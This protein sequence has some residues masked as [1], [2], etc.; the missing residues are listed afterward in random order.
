MA[1]SR[2]SVPR[3]GR[4]A[5][6]GSVIVLTLWTITLLTILV[7]V[8]A[9]QVR[10]DA[11]TAMLHQDDLRQWAALSSAMNQAEMELVLERM[12]PGVEAQERR[13]IGK[14]PGFRFN[15]EPLT[16]N[17]PQDPD[18]V[19]RIYDHRGKINL[20][21]LNP[22]RL[23]ELLAKKL[24]E[25]ATPERL[26]ALMSAW[27]D[28]TDLNNNPAPDGAEDDYYLS[29]DPPYRARNARLETV[30]EILLI[31]GFDELF[32]DVD[33]D[34]AFTL[35]GDDDAQI[36]LNLATVEAMQLL[37]GL[38]DELIA[39]IVAFRRDNEIRG[40]GDLAQLVP[41]EN[42]AVLR[43]WL[44][45]L[46]TSFYYTILVYPKTEKWVETDDGEQLIDAATTA[47]G[48][49]VY[50]PAATQRPQVFKINPYQRI[51]IRLAT[52]PDE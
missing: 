31:K 50:V 49:I 41:A 33:L 11:Q 35:Y 15:G 26:S 21:E 34:A 2:H 10:L 7:A 42:M 39:K 48:E 30:E 16:L 51:P 9:S 32:G 28:W 20:N 6:R 22:P 37:P 19:V 13:E 40:T 43:G 12:A 52:T 27:N 36:N 18:V 4:A 46:R 44:G 38:D 45:L 24:G 8:I 25:A 23:R 17:Y 5:Q 47:L 14:I 3:G 29:L 1:D